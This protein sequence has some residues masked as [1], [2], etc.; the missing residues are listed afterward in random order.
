MRTCRMGEAQAGQGQGSE[1]ATGR[2]L[3]RE[4]RA[5]EI[6]QQHEDRFLLDDQDGEADA[7]TLSGAAQ[8]RI[9][10]LY[11]EYRPR[12][13]RYIRSMQL[14]SDLAEEV[15]QETFMRLTMELIRETSIDNVQGWIVRVAHNLAVNLLKRE[16]HPFLAD[17]VPAFV[18][19]NCV[20]PALG[21][22]E[23][24]SRREQARR[25]KSAIATLKPKHRQCFEMRMQGF[26]YKEISLAL[27]IS[28][29]RA[30]FVVKQVAVRLATICG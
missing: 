29:Q 20:D 13:F 26:P 3:V 17:D 5:D 23:T 21:P 16:R 7:K 14:R 15:I 10:T 12:L 28:E 9:L 30:A 1:A 25:M 24:Y 27:G 2:R 18:I 19:E 8:E 11:D 6:P 22:D 4:D